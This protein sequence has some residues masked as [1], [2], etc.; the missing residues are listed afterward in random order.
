MRRKSLRPFYF[1][2]FIFMPG[3]EERRKSLRP[4]SFLRMWALLCEELH[5]KMM[6]SF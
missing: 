3:V 4:F 1:S 2:F 6:L 5:S